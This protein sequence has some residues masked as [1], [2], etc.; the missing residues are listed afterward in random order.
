[1]TAGKIGWAHF[2]KIPYC[3][4]GDPA[5]IGLRP[6]PSILCHVPCE[7]LA[8]EDILQSLRTMQFS[9]T[10]VLFPSFPASFLI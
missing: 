9:N 2:P 10:Y 1:M 4:G 8:G 7:G 3:Y 6:E 5:L